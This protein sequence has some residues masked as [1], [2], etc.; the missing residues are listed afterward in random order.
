[1]LGIGFFGALANPVPALRVHFHAH[2]E[3][4]ARF[5]HAVWPLFAVCRRNRTAERWTWSPENREKS[6]ATVA[7]RVARFD[8]TVVA[9]VRQM[10]CEG[11]MYREIAAALQG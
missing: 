8:A 2:L 6:R 5:H 11:A 1:M 4:I 9:K 10:R 3:P 7:R